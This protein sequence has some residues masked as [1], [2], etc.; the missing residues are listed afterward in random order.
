MV[1][2]ER[3]MAEETKRVVLKSLIEQGKTVQECKEYLEAMGY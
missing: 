3:E 1:L 2:K